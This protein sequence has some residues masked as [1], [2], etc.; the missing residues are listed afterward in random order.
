MAS[1]LLRQ[2]ALGS[3]WSQ[4]KHSAQR[5]KHREWQTKI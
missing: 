3:K 1:N 4:L 2:T 5:S